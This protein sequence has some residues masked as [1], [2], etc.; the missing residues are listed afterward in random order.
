MNQPNPTL[1]KADHLTASQIPGRVVIKAS[2][3]KPT[4][5]HE[6]RFE[7]SPLTVFPPE[8]SLV[9]IPPTGIVNQVI[10][11]FEVD[12]FFAA[13][14]RVETVKVTDAVGRHEVLVDQ[15]HD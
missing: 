10:T 5:G 3:S 11:P 7:E 1:A 4:P 8:F 9:L 15:A 12:T 6:V 13:T 14:E 2:G